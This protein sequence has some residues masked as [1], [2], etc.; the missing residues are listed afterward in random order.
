ML[1]YPVIGTTQPTQSM[2]EFDDT[3]MCN[4]KDFEKYCKLYFKNDADKSHKYASPL[5][6]KNLSIY[7]PTFI[8][9]AEFDCLRDGGILFAENLK[10][11]GV[12]VSTNFTTRTI[13]GY[14]IV[15]NN[16]IVEDSLKKRIDFL[17]KQFGK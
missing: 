15:K 7:P 6:Q 11:H 16:P 17:K 12:D 5:S 2:L 10:K 13:H 8:E 9:T 14:D 1:I 3:G 4:N